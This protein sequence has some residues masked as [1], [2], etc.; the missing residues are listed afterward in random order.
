M[1]RSDL[2]DYS[3]TY[4]VVKGR[5]S[6]TDTNNAKIKNKK[7]IFKNNAPFRSC[8][9]KI[10]NTF[11]DN[12]EALDV[13]MP[14]DNLLAYSDNYCTTSG[15]LWNYYRDEVIDD[16]NENNDANNYRINNN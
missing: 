2:F 7:L 14:M 6:V 11:I 5:I 1:F 16:A 4:I 8:I 13:V 12:A 10:N 3:D 15:N 9:L